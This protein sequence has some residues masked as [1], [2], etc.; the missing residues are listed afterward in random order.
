MKT[1]IIFGSFL[2]AFAGVA[3][4][5][6]RSVTLVIGGNTLTNSFSIGTNEV[7]IF[8]AALDGRDPSAGDCYLEITKG[9]DQFRVARTYFPNVQ[10]AGPATIALKTWNE[11]QPRVEFQSAFATFEITPESFPPGQTV[12]IPAD[13]PGANIILESSTNLIHWTTATPGPYTNVPAHTFFRLRA[14]RLQ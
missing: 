1:L 2:L 10:F 6:S 12:I 14:E 3:V 5:E 7:A 4:A 13:T 8:R 9:T 11:H